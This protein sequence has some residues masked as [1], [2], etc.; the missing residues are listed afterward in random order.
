M[1][2]IYEGVLYYGVIGFCL[3]TFFLILGIKSKEFQN[4]NKSHMKDALMI[5]G[6]SLIILPMNIA[7]IKIL[8]VEFLTLIKRVT[9]IINAIIMDKVH[10][11][12][13]GLVMKDKIIVG[14]I[15]ILGVS[16]YYL[17]G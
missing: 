1:M 16:L 2:Q 8:A 17:R 11:N 6:V 10:N 5:S 7:V 3:S 13:N 12:S 4:I 9:Q 15:C 14:L